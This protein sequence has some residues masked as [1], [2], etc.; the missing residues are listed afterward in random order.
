MNR[1]PT[2]LLRLPVR[3]LTSTT[4]RRVGVNAR[5]ATHY[6]G[7]SAS[8]IIVEGRVVVGGCS[9]RMLQT[10]P[11]RMG[12][13]GDAKNFI[14]GL[15]V[16]AEASHILVKGTDPESEQKIRKIMEE[17]GN[18]PEKFI[19]A[20]KQISDCPSS[21]SGGSLGEFGRYSMVPEFDAVVFGEDTEIGVVY[22]PIKTDFGYHA[23]LVTRRSDRL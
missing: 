10:S 2:N 20:A 14:V 21:G 7:S 15:T 13:L 19:K 1:L 8:S 17:V 3:T 23:I 11:Y 16:R 5:G 6:L 4:R 9:T 18:D 22:G 12:I